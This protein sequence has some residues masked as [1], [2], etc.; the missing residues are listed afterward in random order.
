M[1]TTDSFPT[2]V[3]AKLGHVLQS[4]LENWARSRFLTPSI[5]APRR[6]VSRLYSF[7]DVVAIRVIAELRDAGIK[8]RALHRVVRYLSTHK[9]LGTTEVLATTNLVTNGY[10]VFEVTDT[11]TFSTLRKPGQ[12]V[13][14]V[15]PLGELVNEIQTTARALSAA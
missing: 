12:S 10:D 4:D 9:G 14:F 5:P 11:A 7:R 13:L 2:D 1:N 15:V 3:A 8:P 6:G